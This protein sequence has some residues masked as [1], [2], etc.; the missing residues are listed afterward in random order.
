MPG[1][2]EINSLLYKNSHL[3]EGALLLVV[4]PCIPIGTFS[5]IQQ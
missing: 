5:E 1:K 3:G 4:L 2:I